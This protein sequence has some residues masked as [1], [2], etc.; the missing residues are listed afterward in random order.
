MTTATPPMLVPSP[1]R[2]PV[3]LLVAFAAVMFVVLAAR[4]AGTSSASGVDTRLDAVVDPLGAA[5]EWFV[6]HAVELGSPSS[7]MVMVCVL[8][9]V[10]LALGRRRVAVLALLGPGLTGV[11]TSLLKPA[12]G[13]TIDGELAFPSGHTGGATS[14]GLVAA[15]L[16]I[17]VIRPGRAGALAILA[18]GAVVVGG[19]VAAAMVASNAHYPTD[20][21]GGF[22]IAVVMVCGAALVLDRAAAYRA[23]AR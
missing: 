13:R 9:L 19:G 4:Y 1:L 14:V 18:A 10:C 22:C 8:A 5:H 2:R 21:M 17:S 7:V 11:C 12:V 6:E 3:A 16:L 23:Q 20:T 15:L